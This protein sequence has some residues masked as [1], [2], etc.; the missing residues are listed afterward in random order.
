MAR[1]STSLPVPLSPQTSTVES[2]TAA[3][4]A[5]SRQ[6]VKAGLL[7]TM[8]SSTLRG[9][10]V[11]LDA[12]GAASPSAGIGSAVHSLT[13]LKSHSATGRGDRATTAARSRFHFSYTGQ[14]PAAA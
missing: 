9:T 10:L 5:F 12:T 3:L 6:A 1:A 7:P 2:A 14:S 4:R 11:C 13:P 8:P